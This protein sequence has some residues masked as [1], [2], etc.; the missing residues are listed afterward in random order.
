MPKIPTFTSTRSIT[1]ETASVGSN[2]QL[3]VNNT[4]A[5]A[6][7]PVNGISTPIITFFADNE[8]GGLNTMLMTKKAIKR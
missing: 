8:M 5:S 1:A 2:I 4:P 6:L 7:T 3:N